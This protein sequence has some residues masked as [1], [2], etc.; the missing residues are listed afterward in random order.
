MFPRERWPGQRSISGSLVSTTRRPSHLS[1]YSWKRFIRKIDPLSSGVSTEQFARDAVLTSSFGGGPESSQ[2]MEAGDGEVANR[3]V[4]RFLRDGSVS[5][6]AGHRL[7][8]CERS[9]LGSARASCCRIKSWAASFLVQ[10]NPLF[11]RKGPRNVLHLRARTAKS[12]RARSW[13][14]GEGDSPGASCD[15]TRSRRG[16]GADK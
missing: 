8:H 12:K 5:W 7:R 3:T 14:H 13:G 16:G 9:A 11:G 10:S 1:S 6:I 4:C 2:R 15:R